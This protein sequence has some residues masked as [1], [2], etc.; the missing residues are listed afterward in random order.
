MWLSTV[1]LPEISSA[2]DDLSSKYWP[3]G[4]SYAN[5]YGASIGNSSKVKTIDIDNR[6]FIGGW[7]ADSFVVNETLDVFDDCGFW[8]D[9]YALG[10]VGIG[11]NL[12]VDGSLTANAM[13]QA[14]CVY[15]DGPVAITGNGA[16]LQIGNTTLNEQELIRLKQLLQ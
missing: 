12:A 14:G 8:S 1:V 3:Q 5:C 13:V 6:D 7:D 2:I 15:A 9:V 11:G 4:G 10:D 16:T